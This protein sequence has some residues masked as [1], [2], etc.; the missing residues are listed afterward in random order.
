MTCLPFGMGDIE[1]PESSEAACRTS[2][3]QT[4]PGVPIYYNNE[5]IGRPI[6]LELALQEQVQFVIQTMV[7]RL[8][9]KPVLTS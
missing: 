2:L 5:I 4:R 6:K 1:F 3:M 7:P 8:F 9:N